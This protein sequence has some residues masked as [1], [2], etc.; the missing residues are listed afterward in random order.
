MDEAFRLSFA[1]GA[2]GSILSW[3]CHFVGINRPIIVVL[4]LSVQGSGCSRIL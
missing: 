4:F 2:Q 1:E 3:S